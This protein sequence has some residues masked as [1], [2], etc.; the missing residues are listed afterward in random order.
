M[1]D[2]SVEEAVPRATGRSKKPRPPFYQ[3]RTASPISMHSTPAAYFRKAPQLD[4]HAWN[5]GKLY[6]ARP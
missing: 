3:I 4:S 1:R 6:H 2:V 5:L